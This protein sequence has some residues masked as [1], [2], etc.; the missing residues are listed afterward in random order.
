LLVIETLVLYNASW[1]E[2]DLVGERVWM[3]DCGTV[4]VIDRD[5][6]F[7]AVV[8]AV[9]RR[10]GLMPICAESAEEGLELVGDVRPGLAIV[11]V[12]L[13]GSNG[14]AVLH[15]LHAQ[16]DD[17]LPV[18]LVSTEHTDSFDRTAGLLVGA[19]DYVVK[20]L[21]SGELAARVR[22]SLR[23]AGVV[24]NGNGQTREVT[25]S[26][27]LSPREREILDLLASGRSQREIA[28][29]LVISSKTV[30][31]HIQHVLS[32]LGVHS[33]AEAVAAAYR[34]GLVETDVVAHAFDTVLIGAD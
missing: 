10:M 8:A 31:T 24:S 15:D 3:G 7:R 23:R 25:Q 12:E 34:R 29:T 20:P 32:K 28:T 1:D 21:D 18:I 17:D 27:P 2:G 4:L 16:F 26:P 14:L 13:P 11:E 19:D 33:R 6:A 5:P 9:A 30:A 22:R